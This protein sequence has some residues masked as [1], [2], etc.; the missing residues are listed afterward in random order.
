MP[1][2]YLETLI[3]APVQRCFDLSRSIDLHMLSTAHTGEKAIAGRTDG[4][5]GAG[6]WV[7]WRAKHFGVWQT[8][9][10]KITEYDSPV[11]FCDEM[12]KGAFKQFR[13]EHHFREQ[14]QFTLMTDKFDFQSPLGPLGQLFNQLILS[15]YMKKLLLERNRVIKQA[16]ET[17]HWKE[18][19]PRSVA[20]R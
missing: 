8:L 5:I 17:E 19:V 10:S 16:A 13:H 11:Y 18:V 6:E 12:V 20:N 7:T 4:L 1:S 15:R 14:G 2:F 9:T 3:K